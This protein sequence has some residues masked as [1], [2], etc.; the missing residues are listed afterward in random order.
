MK[1]RIVENVFQKLE[2]SIQKIEL[3]GNNIIAGTANMHGVFLSSNNG[4]NWT[5]IFRY[6]TGVY[7]L[8]IRGT[9]IFAGTYFSAGIYL[10]TNNGSSWTASTIPTRSFYSFAASGNTIFAGSD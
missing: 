9:N 8:A 2:Y 7:T 3:F 6:S 1:D 4:A 5:N 10:S